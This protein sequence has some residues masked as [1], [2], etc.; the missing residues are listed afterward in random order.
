M[1]K[2]TVL[3]ILLVLSG[4]AGLNNGMGQG[5]GGQGSSGSSHRH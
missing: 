5:G 4:C 3:I 2:A 1:R